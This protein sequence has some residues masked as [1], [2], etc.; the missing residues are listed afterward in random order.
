[1]QEYLRYIKND[2]KERAKNSGGFSLLEILVASAIASIIL[3]MVGAAYTS[4]LR[5]IKDVT[6]YAEFHESINLAFSKIDRDISNA[7]YDRDNKKVCF[8]GD[9]S[10]DSSILNF[11]TVDYRKMHIHGSMQNPVN[12]SDIHEIGYYLK[13]DTEYPGVNFLVR[14]E[15]RHYD[16][17][18]EQGGIENVILKNV[19]S[20]KLEF[21]QRNSFTTV[22]DSRRNQR[23]PQAVKVTLKVKNYR[24]AE[25]EFTFLSIINSIQRI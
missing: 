24:N 5:S 10:G 1:M 4:A 17:E 2:L 18:P 23:Y 21:K 6:G 3:L 8:I 12:S 11:I 7:F 9:F 15:Q 22:W 19:I 16:D 20:L 14:R 13:P 25:E